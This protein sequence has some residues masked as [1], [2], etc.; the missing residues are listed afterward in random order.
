MSCLVCDVKEQGLFLRIGSFMLFL[1]VQY[2]FAF[3]FL[4]SRLCLR[5]IVGNTEEFGSRRCLGIFFIEV[6]GR[7]RLRSYEI[8]SSRLDVGYIWGFFNDVLGVRIL[9]GV[10]FCRGGFVLEVIEEV[11]QLGSGL[12]C[13]VGFVFLG[14]VGIFVVEIYIFVVRR[15]VF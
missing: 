8:Q 5:V 15:L 2:V 6:L 13:L 7:G 1:F 4:D 3:F 14:D 9:F 11:T 10:G 12:Q